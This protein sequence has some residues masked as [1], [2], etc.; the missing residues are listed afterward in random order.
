VQ[1]QPEVKPVDF[2]GTKLK[3]VVG[4]SF[5]QGDVGAKAFTNLILGESA[6]TRLK[7]FNL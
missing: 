6:V 1:T 5:M 4:D 3:R 7:G 2:N